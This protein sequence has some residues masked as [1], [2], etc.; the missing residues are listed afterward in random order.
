MNFVFKMM[1]VSFKMMNVVLKMMSVSFKMMHFAL[2]M[3]R[4]SF[5]GFAVFDGVGICIKIDEFA[6]KTMDFVHKCYCGNHNLP[7]F[8]IQ[9][10]SLLIQNSSIVNENSPFKIPYS[11]TIILHHRFG[12]IL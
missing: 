7:L 3:K 12:P 5:G 6:L 8:L 2:K 1:S 4:S 10:S 9:S 11:E